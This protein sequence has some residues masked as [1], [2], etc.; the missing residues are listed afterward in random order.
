MRYTALCIV[1]DAEKTE[2][3][4]EDLQRSGFTAQE[5][6]VV[7]AQASPAT[8]RSDSSSSTRR[9][10]PA[11]QPL[12]ARSLVGAALGLIAGLSAVS[13]PGI[14]TAIGSGHLTA[15]LDAPG[16]H[17]IGGALSA[18]GMSQ[19]KAQWYGSLLR[20]GHTLISVNTTNG[21]EMDM[22][23]QIF[24]DAGASLCEKA[25]DPGDGD[26]TP[27][28]APQPQEMLNP[29]NAVYA[30]RIREST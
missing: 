6:S 23:L 19:D 27:L 16:V 18:C 2:A 20:P 26:A 8:D 22:L 21:Y 12:G 14:G 4:L 29:R 3:I 30:D 11:I 5:I 15:V 13:I 10:I 9:R 7:S 25:E 24:R 28:P 1:S 17:G